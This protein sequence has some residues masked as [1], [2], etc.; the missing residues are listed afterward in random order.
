MG[1]FQAP[2]AD[3]PILRRLRSVDI[4][5]MTPMQALT[6]LAELKKEAGE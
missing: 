2:T 3:D 6:L 5:T 1:L 4:N